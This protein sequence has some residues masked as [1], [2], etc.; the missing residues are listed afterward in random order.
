MEEV[1]LAAEAPVVA[2]FSL[3]QHGEV[4]LELLLVLPAGA[5]DALELR[6]AR[7]AAPVGAGDL[8][9]LERMP[10]LAGRRQVRADAEVEPVALAVDRDLLALRQRL[11][12]LGLVL[13]PDRGEVADRLFAV[14][15]LAA[16]RLVAVDDLVHAL[17][18]GR[19]VGGRE[20]GLPGEDRKSTSLN[21]SH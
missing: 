9:Q 19:K 13:L 14:P 1:H 6:V 3:L 20:G 10:E 5:V 12:M 15:H 18:D 16:D 17:L 11:D 4:G 8:H 7:V 21:S 2:L